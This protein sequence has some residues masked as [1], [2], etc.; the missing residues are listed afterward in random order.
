MCFREVVNEA[1]RLKG[2]GAVFV[3][4]P[5][6]DCFEGGGVFS[7]NEEFFRSSTVS[8]GVIAAAR[9]NGLRLCVC[10]GAGVDSG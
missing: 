8:G 3:H 5:C 4:E 7:C 9:F 10:G 6:E 1:D 2:I